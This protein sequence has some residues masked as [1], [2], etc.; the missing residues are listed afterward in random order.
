MPERI[1][2]YYDEMLVPPESTLWKILSK[3]VFNLNEAFIILCTIKAYEQ[4]GVYD[5]KECYVNIYMSEE[6][7]N[8]KNGVKIDITDKEMD[9]NFEDY[10]ISLKN[11]VV[12]DFLDLFF[13]KSIDKELTVN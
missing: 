12:K 5:D 6:D 13:K 9:E 8:E 1:L 10:E 4:D 7:F 2:V 3:K 11:D